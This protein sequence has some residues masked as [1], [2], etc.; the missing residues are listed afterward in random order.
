MN[1]F[2]RI[3]NTERPTPLFH[4]P[5]DLPEKGEWKTWEKGW[6]EQNQ[7]LVTSVSTGRIQT[8]LDYFDVVVQDLKDIVLSG[9]SK[10]ELTRY[11]NYLDDLAQAFGLVLDGSDHFPD[12]DEFRYRV[13]L[14][15]ARL[16][17]TIETFRNKMKEGV[18]AVTV[19]DRFVGVSWQQGISNSWSQGWLGEWNTVKRYS[20]YAMKKTR[21]L[22]V[23]WMKGKGYVI[24]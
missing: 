1:E 20:L 12:P 5:K 10:A 15:V 7:D 9:A 21:S 18:H 4:K 17:F 16:E 24:S 8:N 13:N 11:R 6:I 3:I 23:E 14:R 22:L 19:K 2:G